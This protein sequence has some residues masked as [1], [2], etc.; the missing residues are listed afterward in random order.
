M[1]KKEEKKEKE[2]K[3]RPLW[4]EPEEQMGNLMRIEEDIHRMMRDFW[5][6]PFEFGGISVMPRAMRT[7]PID[8]SETD[9]ELVAKAD[10]PGFSKDE[11]KLKVTENSMEISAEKK[12]EIVKKEKAFFRQE[13]AFGSMHR[14]MTLPY[15]VKPDETRAKFENGVL[16]VTMPKTEIKRRV[17][18]IS[19]E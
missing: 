6:R 13:R 15:T 5:K 17:R 7:I 4:F 12:R 1:P 16:M 10:L 8:L 11:V 3:R 14:M 2:G 18:E 19:P 9:G